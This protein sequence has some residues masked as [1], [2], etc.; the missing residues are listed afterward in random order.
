M[1]TKFEI[2]YEQ[3]INEIN[4]SKD[5]ISVDTF[6]Y[7]FKQNANN[8]L[9]CEFE[10]LNSNDELI[11]VQANILNN[12]TIEFH[13]LNG[14]TKKVLTEKSFMMKY[15]K[16]YEKFK[17]ALKEYNEE[18]KEPDENDETNIKEKSSLT[19]T[20]IPDIISFNTKLNE[21]T[22]KNSSKIDIIK[23]DGFTFEFQPV[24]ETDD[25]QLI[26]GTFE[27]INN[28]PGED[29]LDKYKVIGIVKLLNKNSVPIKF[30]FIN[31]ED[32]EERF[33]VPKTDFK[34]EFPEYFQAFYSALHKYESAKN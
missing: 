12:G 19:N 33:E 21:I 7:K 24:E 11:Q 29:E 8:D 27:L 30:V 2:L 22:N 1:K 9:V 10:T 18:N 16:D 15:Y 5:V 31:P 25:Q 28:D 23:Q 6:E 17:S 20:N 34:N 3:I 26:Q 14:K 32:E 13:L 4:S